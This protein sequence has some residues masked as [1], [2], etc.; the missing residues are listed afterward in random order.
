[1]IYK[2]LECQCLHCLTWIPLG[3]QRFKKQSLMV[4]CNFVDDCYVFKIY[5]CLF[6]C[7]AIIK[8][9][10]CRDCLLLSCVLYCSLCPCNLQCNFCRKK[11]CR[12][13]QLVLWPAVRL[14]F[15]LAQYLK[16]S[17]AFCLCRIVIGSF[18]KNCETSCSGG[19][20]RC[21]L[22]RSIAKSKSCFYFLCNLQRNVSLRD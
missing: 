18:S 7:C 16:M 3:M 1:M 21:N 10:Q 8:V 20:T 19:V 5:V 11:Y 4:I 6:A 17:A 15:T 13:T 14:Y 2:S 22:S 12:R 9:L